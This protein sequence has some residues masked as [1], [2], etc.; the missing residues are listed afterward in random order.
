MEKAAQNG[1]ILNFTLSLKLGPILENNS[2]KGFVEDCKN[3][4]Q[5]GIILGRRE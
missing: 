2:K 5:P 4:W 3:G 1:G